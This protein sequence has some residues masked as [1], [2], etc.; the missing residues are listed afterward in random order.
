MDKLR[1]LLNIKFLFWFLILVTIGVSLQ[2]YSLGL[3]HIKN[4]LIFKNSFFNL[5][6]Y[7]DIYATQ[8]W[9]NLDIDLFKYSPAFALII[10]PMA[11]MPIIIGV[12][13]WNLLNALLLFFAIKS[14]SLPDNKKAIL[15]WILFVELLTSIQNCQSNA[16]V[17]ALMIF[18]F[19]LLERKNLFLAALCLVLSVYIKLFGAV[20]IIL[21]LFHPDKVKAI[22]YIAFWGVVFFLLPLF[23]ISFDQLML[24]YKSWGTMLAQDQSA[25]IGLSVMG[26][27]HSWFSIDVSKMMV[28][29]IGGILL[30]L[31]LIFIKSYQNILYRTLYLSSIMIWVI[32]FNHRAESPTFIIALSGMAIWFVS[33]RTTPISIFLII[34][35]ILFTSLSPTDIFPKMIRQNYIVP[36][37]LKALPAVIIWAF[38]QV[39]LFLLS[40]KS[41]S[42]C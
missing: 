13:V 27:I 11:A 34:F 5:I 1:F 33:D 2:K 39:R 16:L 23:T 15:F 14:L 18:T 38:I 36:Y 24:L 8:H 9:E 26:I 20:A 42:Q 35:A 3:D 32:I 22:L 37:A 7:Q 6:N 17:A 21:F 10:A 4:F 41:T 19:T 25:S 40:I 29:L 30:F 28:Q 12:V 31:P